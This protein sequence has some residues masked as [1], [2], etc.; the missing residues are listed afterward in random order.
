MAHIGKEC[1]DEVRRAIENKRYAYIIYCGGVIFLWMLLLISLSSELITNSSFIGHFFAFQHSFFN[2]DAIKKTAETVGFGS[3]LIAWIY[4]VLDKEELGFQYSDLLRAVYPAYHYF[5]LGHLAAILLCV[6]LAESGMMEG[7][8][9]SLA[10]VGTGCVIHWKALSSLVFISS[11]RKNIA[12][13]EWSRKVSEWDVKDSEDEDE[14]FRHQAILYGISDVLSVH[15]RDSAEKLQCCLAQALSKFISTFKEETEEHRKQILLNISH[16]WDRIMWDR[17]TSERSLL[18]DSILRACLRETSDIGPICAGYILW[19][20]K[21]CADIKSMDKD[22]R[23]QEAH[24]LLLRNELGTM[25][26]RF[27]DQDKLVQSTSAVF[28]LLVW[29]H[30]L[31]GEICLSRD[32]FLSFPYEDDGKNRELLQATAGCV[33]PATKCRLYFEMAFQQTVTLINKECSLYKLKRKE[34]EAIET[35]G[36]TS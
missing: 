5:V 16:L 20:Y 29:M 7:S 17:T 10:I 22:I 11:K 31:C 19:L 23:P 4:A 2:I 21:N 26:I 34:G 33:F 12:I 18:L 28:T 15:D 27:C 24:L 14:D 9:L 35:A 8:L 25:Q 30:F 3:V 6:W 32:Y 1:V 13:N 36:H